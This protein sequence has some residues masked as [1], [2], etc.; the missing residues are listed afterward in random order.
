MDDVHRLKIE[1]LTEEA[2]EPFGQIVGEAGHTPIK[3]EAVGFAHDYRMD[4]SVDG[5]TELLFVRFDFQPWTFTRLERHLNVTQSF[6]PL[7]GKSSILVVA[8]PTD[9]ND[10]ENIPAPEDLKAFLMDG[11]QAVMMWKGTWHTINRFAVFPPNMEM[12]V[13]TCIETTEELIRIQ[14]PGAAPP[15]LTQ[16]ADYKERFGITFG[17]TW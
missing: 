8:P 9:P 15:R 6:F 4:F 12:A 16:R 14:Q 7:G 1:T 3:Y 13:L 11:T 17:M 10:W 2:F 5:T